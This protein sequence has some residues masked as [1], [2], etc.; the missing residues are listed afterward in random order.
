[1]IKR[2]AVLTTGGDAPGMNACLRAI[3]RTGIHLGFEMYGIHQGYSGLIWANNLYYDKNFNFFEKDGEHYYC[4]DYS[5]KRF[6]AENKKKAVLLYNQE[7]KYFIYNDLFV[8]KGKYLCLD[9]K[10]QSTLELTPNHYVEP[11]MQWSVDG[12]VNAGGT[13]LGTSRCEEFKEKYYQKKAE[14]NLQI[15]GIENVIVIGGEGS[16]RGA[17]DLSRLRTIDNR[18]LR[19]I[20]IPGSIDNDIGCTAVSIGTYTAVNTITN[21]CYNIMS[22]ASSHK[23]VF[24]ID[25][26]GRD[27]GYLALSSFVA[28]GA[29]YV[30]FRESGKSQKQEIK[31]LIQKIKYDFS[32]SRHKQRFIIIKSENYKLDSLQLKKILDKAFI[33]T[34]QKIGVRVTHLGHVVRGG[35]ATSFDSLLACR[36]GSVAVHLIAQKKSCKMVGWI[37]YGKYERSNVDHGVGIWDIKE[38]IKETKKVKQAKHPYIYNRNLAYYKLGTLLAE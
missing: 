12:I 25:V 19:V 20:A 8:K 3:V 22:T 9:P 24:I 6:I 1:M 30:L 16:I 27:C 5:R 13:I 36:L 4:I 15:L 14:K 23:R 35:T 37:G 21:A 2:I 26:M 29:D 32:L 33:N 18:P 28:S 17:Y 31:N 11:L 38:V 10:A 7:S 34:P